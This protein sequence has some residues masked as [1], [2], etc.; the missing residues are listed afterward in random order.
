M[1][2]N[3]I[4]FLLSFAFFSS[5][6]AQDLPLEY[7][8]STDGHR[9]VVGNTISNGFYD[10]SE[11]DTLSL[12]FSQ[13]N[14]WTLLGQNY[15]DKI[16]IPAT[17][18]HNGTTYDSV[19]V[20]FKGNTSYRR[21][22][23][24]DK[25]S[26]AISL[27]AY[28][29]DQNI[30]GYESLNLSNAFEDESHMRE[31]LYL[32][33]IRKHIAAAKG[34][35]IQLFINGQ[36]WG[37][38]P[39]VQALNKEHVG[40]WFLDNDATRWRCEATVTTPGS[41]RFNVGFSSLNYLGDDSTDHYT[42]KST[43]LENPWEG[44][45]VACSLI[46]KTNSSAS[47]DLLKDHL[48]LDQTLW[49]LASEII[50]TD[51]DGYVFKG[52]MDYYA[53]FDVATERLVPIEYDGNSCMALN[54]ASTWSPFYKETDT[55][56]PLMNILMKVPEIRQRYLAHFRT[57]LNTSFDTAT[58]ISQI[59]NYAT[60]ISSRYGNDP[61]KLYS[62]NQHNTEIE[63]LKQFVRTRSSFLFSNSEIQQ[64]GVGITG[65]SHYSG[66]IE[67]ANPSNKDSVL[68]LATASTP[69]SVSNMNIF[70]GTGLAGRFHS[71]AMYDDGSHGDGASGDGQYG[72]YIP[73]QS[74]GEYVRYYIE[75]VSNNSAGTRVY[76]P[77][78]AEHETF[79]YRVEGGSKVS[80]DVVINEI[81]SS[82]KLAFKDASGEDDD[83]IELYNNGSGT[84]D[85]SGYHLTDN[86]ADFLQW[87]FP[88]GTT[89]GAGEYLIVWCD[90]DE[91]QQGLHSNFKLSA[92]GD[93]VSLITPIGDIA[94][95]VTF[96]E[97]SSNETY[98]RVP[99]GTGSFIWQHYTPLK[100]NETLSSVS[101]ISSVND[102][103][104]VYPN[105]AKSIIDVKVSS[106]FVN[107]ILS[108]YSMGGR[109]ML[110]QELEESTTT[111]DVSS[112]ESAVYIIKLRNGVNKRLVVRP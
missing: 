90:K 30:E 60:L 35:Y 40:E 15:D 52:G 66:G 41:P 26:F 38:Y 62:V 75:S 31:V 32:N 53:Y 59:D 17:L 91:S 102:D 44:L 2:V 25:K 45:A 109:L 78:G 29:D 105:P 97:S 76:E 50:F 1:K 96:G 19:G 8:Y 48:D 94:D 68:I 9:L 56:F 47:A 6:F 20:R 89:I 100:S 74:G 55:D 112:L 67:W 64:Q 22:G 108:I 57:I 80:S 36:D 10:E 43:D 24:S 13:S 86:N 34:N 49:F 79:I 5:A 82:N 28:I 101:A 7:N 51:D 98:S 70:Y 42:L 33:S 4:V 84:V 103:F 54:K 111:I 87:E 63:N 46:D 106:S 73:V 21:L 77:A 83:W 99:N 107:E 12:Q 110:E 88:Q 92:S 69:G 37:I 93:M 95:E 14:Y 16:E 81:M 39:N 85:L 11:I 61:K 3:K 72:G 58:M 18:T 71:I 104:I 65:V 23:N 27:D